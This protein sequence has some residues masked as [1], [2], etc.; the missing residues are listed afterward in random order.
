[1]DKMDGDS[2]IHREFRL[3]IVWFDKKLNSAYKNPQTGHKEQSK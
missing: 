2:K 1:M 3:M